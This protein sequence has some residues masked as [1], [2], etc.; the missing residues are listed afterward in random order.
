MRVSEAKSNGVFHTPKELAEYV[1]TLGVEHPCSSV[2]DPCYGEGALLLAAY[3]RLLDV[4]CAEPSQHLFG[5]DIAP[6]LGAIQDTPL[7]ESL[8]SHQLTERDFLEIGEQECQSKFDAILMNPPFVRH[9]LLQKE[10]QD[11]ARRAVQEEISLPK[12]S[13]LWAYFV[14]HSLEFI[15]EGGSLVAILPWSFLYADYSRPVRELLA[16]KFRMIRVSVIGQRLF[17][18]VEE[19]VLVM[20]ARGFGS[21]SSDIGI[22]YSLEVP[23]KQPTWMP[24]DLET[25]SGSPW[26]ALTPDDARQV[27]SRVADSLGFTPL[28]KFARVRVGTVTGANSFFVIPREKAESMNLPRTIL[29]PIVRHSNELCRLTL[30]SANDIKYVLLLIPEDM[31]LPDTLKDYIETGVDSGLNNRYHT[32]KRAKWYSIPEQPAPDAFFPYMTKVVPF[33]A[34]NPHGALSTNTVHAV[35][36]LDNVSKETRE[37]VQL[38]MLTSLSQLSLELSART[39]GGG[40]LKIEPSA[41]GEI[42][43]FPGNGSDL[44]TDLVREVDDLLANGK[45]LEAVNRVDNW[46]VANMDVPRDDMDYI[47]RYFHELRR[48]RAGRVTAKAAAHVVHTEVIS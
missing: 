8:D 20:T 11:R 14:V 1:A 30:S 44:P 39:Y 27:L 47:A 40:V 9:H 17:E 38:S 5:Y 18:G 26:R 41:A 32:R 21:P 2:L 48:L 37:W 25:W 4:G 35:D 46:L 3:G 7:K 16:E 42:L 13:D 19:R 10:V 12:T 29:R 43:V 34:L 28:R 22:H 36:F 15:S 31:D 45:R 24:V 6:R 33:L 23:T